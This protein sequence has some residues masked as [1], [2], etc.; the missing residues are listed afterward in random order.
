MNCL[1]IPLDITSVTIE[2]VEFTEEG[3]IFVTITSMIEGA[4]CHVC[5]QEITDFYGED[6]EIISSCKFS[7]DRNCGAGRLKNIDY[8][9][10]GVG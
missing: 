2:S 10:Q 3:E 7:C 8:P 1:E 6:R 4:V 5:G 9:D